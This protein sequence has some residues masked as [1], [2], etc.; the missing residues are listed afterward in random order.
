MIVIEACIGSAT[1]RENVSEAEMTLS[2]EIHTHCSD[3]EYRFI[4]AISASQQPKEI[5]GRTITASHTNENFRHA[6]SV[7]V[8]LSC[9]HAIPYTF[10]KAP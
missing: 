1:A 8:D 6:I 10:V 9:L 4:T 3:I 2:L 7:N 5:R